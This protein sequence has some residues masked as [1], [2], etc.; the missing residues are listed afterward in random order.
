MIRLW[1][2]V[3]AIMC[4]LFAGC[5]QK[6]VAHSFYTSGKVRTS[7]IVRNNLLDGPSIMYYES[8]ATMSEANYRAGMLNGKSTSYYENGTKKAMAE[9]KDGV[10]HGLSTKWREDGSEET[11]ANFVNGVLQTG[12]DCVKPLP[13][14]DKKQAHE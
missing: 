8:G 7:A 10:L 9:Y 13:I 6:D 1:W 14:H 5:W 4:M 12:A 2:I 11:R 3:A